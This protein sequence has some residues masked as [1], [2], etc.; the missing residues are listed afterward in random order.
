MKQ[1]MKKAVGIVNKIKP[2]EYLGRLLEYVES[3]KQELV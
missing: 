2:S 3:Y 1:K